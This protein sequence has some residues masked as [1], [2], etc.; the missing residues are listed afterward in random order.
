MQ[1]AAYISLILCYPL[2]MWLQG[3]ETMSGSRPYE[4]NIFEQVIQRGIFPRG[5]LSLYFL[6]TLFLSD[7][8]QDAMA[9]CI[10]SAKAKLQHK[11]GLKTNANPWQFTRYFRGVTS[12]GF[13]DMVFYAHFGALCGPVYMNVCWLVKAS[14][15]SVFSANFTTTDDPTM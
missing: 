13:W 5:R 8:L 11:L 2:A 14:G 15:D 9:T 10:I 7:L 4:E 6:L 3:G 12:K 1:T